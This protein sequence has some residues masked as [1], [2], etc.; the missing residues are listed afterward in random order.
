MD[1]PA[2]SPVIRL[3][4]R[5]GVALAAAIFS[6]VVVGLIT[7]GVWTLTELDTKATH[8]R[9]DAATALRLAHSGGVHAMSVFRQ[10]LNDTTVNRLLR[11]YDNVA[12]TADDGLLIGFPGLGST[13]NI[14]AAGRAGQNGSYLVRVYDDPNDGDANAFNDTNWRFL[15]RCTGVTTRGARAVVDYVV[16]YLPP[17]PAIA[18]NGDAVLQGGPAVT[19]ACGDIHTNGNVTVSGTITVN[20]HLTTSGTASGTG[21]VVNAASTTVGVEP[22]VGT[23][24]IPTM[25]AAEYCP[26][27]EYVLQAD[28]FILRR[29]DM[30]L[31]NAIST[32]VFGWRRTSASP[33]VWTSNGS[34]LS[35][36]YCVMGNAVLSGNPGSS[37]SPLP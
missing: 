29:S 19:G 16:K 23:I 15:V 4:S 9:E 13:V 8:N 32:V 11:G 37:L 7:A 31:H 22:V 10:Q 35:G 24:P 6:I 5:P 12:N 20:D 27:A 17:L 2:E 33:L 14:P 1:I 25:T 21:T 28:G 30:S 18:F 3:R 36:S 34:I 26:G